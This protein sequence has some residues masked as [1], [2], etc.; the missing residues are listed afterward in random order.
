MWTYY[1]Y[2]IKVDADGDPHILVEV[3][4][5]GEEYCYYSNGDGSSTESDD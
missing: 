4:P 5:C 3:L 1:N 2:D